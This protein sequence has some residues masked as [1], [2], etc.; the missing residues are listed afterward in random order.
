M[1]NET[2]KSTMEKKPEEK[3]EKPVEKKVEAETG[4]SIAKN[5]AVI[6]IRGLINL[7][8]DIND[9]LDMLRLYRKNY[10][11]VLPNIPAIIGMVKKAKDYITWGEIDDETYK[12][13]VEKKSEEYKGREADSKNK[14][15]YKNKYFVSN[16]K[17]YKKYFRLSP[18]R[19]GFEKKGIKTPF[20][21]G[22]VLGNRKEKINGS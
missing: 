17:K 1:E 18:P 22:G 21:K 15:N 11:V 14:I 9:T 7:R 5:I 10:C 2:E 6:R 4:K 20:S 8:G 19:G 3:A 12:L 13:L 16:N